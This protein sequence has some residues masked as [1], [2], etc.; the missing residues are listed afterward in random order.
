MI[1]LRLLRERPRIEHAAHARHYILAAIEQISDRLALHVGAAAGVP[2]RL[3]VAGA[4]GEDVALNIAGEGDAAIGGD[5]AAA[6]RAEAELVGP[7]GFAG[8]VVD[9]LDEA[10]ALGLSEGAGGYGRG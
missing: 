3:A 4:Q 1:G 10:L 2:E 5:D 6:G 9:G 7:A 8:L